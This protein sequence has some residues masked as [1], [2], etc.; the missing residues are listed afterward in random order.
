MLTILKISLLFTAVQLFYLL[1]NFLQKKDNFHIFFILGFNIIVVVF[2]YFN[3]ICPFKYFEH[4]LVGVNI[5][6]NIYDIYKNNFKR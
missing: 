6:S 2:A 1:L 5:L 4:I 3:I